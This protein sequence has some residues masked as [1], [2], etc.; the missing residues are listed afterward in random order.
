MYIYM[1]IICA[2]LAAAPVWQLTGGVLLGELV[3][4]PIYIYILLSL[5]LSLSLS[6]YT[7][8][9]IY[10]HTHTYMEAYCLA[11]LVAEPDPSV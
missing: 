8:I 10:T 6:L 5:S 2:C 3:V 1:Y 4:E 11:K 7:Y 9:Y